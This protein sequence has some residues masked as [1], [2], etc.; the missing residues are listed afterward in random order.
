MDEQ[1]TSLRSYTIQTGEG[2]LLE[3]EAGD[4]LAARIVNIQDD[5]RGVDRDQITFDFT[6]C[7]RGTRIIMP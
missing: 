3:N 7:E 4:V 1:E 6:I 5:T 2:F